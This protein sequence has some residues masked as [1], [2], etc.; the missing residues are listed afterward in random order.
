MDAVTGDVTL[1]PAGI[2]FAGAG[3]LFAIVGAVGTQEGGGL[4]A[5]GVFAG[6]DIV[7]GALEGGGGGEDVATETGGGVGC[8]VP[9]GLTG[10]LPRSPILFLKL[11]RKSSNSAG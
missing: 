1:G 5:G 8:P 2:A 3:T 10:D 9:E 6:G 11:V 7:A 4:A